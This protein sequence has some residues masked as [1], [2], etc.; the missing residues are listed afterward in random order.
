MFNSSI[1]EK[2]NIF[3]TQVG[4]EIG[5][6]EAEVVPNRVTDLTYLLSNLKTLNS[7]ES[8]ESI[9]P[10]SKSADPRNKVVLRRLDSYEIINLRRLKVH[11]NS[12]Y[13]A[14]E[15]F[16]LF[17]PS[18]TVYLEGQVKEKF[19]FSHGLRDKLHLLTILF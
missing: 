13:K 10:K 18:C 9:I 1:C 11:R 7:P 15:I 6:L 5:C 8:L 19:K 14:N 4:A 2:K 17:L 12:T 16:S 3:L